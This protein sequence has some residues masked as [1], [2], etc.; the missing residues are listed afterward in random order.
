[1]FIMMP[2]QILGGFVVLSALLVTLMGWYLGHV[3]EALGQF[4]RR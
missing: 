4:L 1:M 2:L 3:E